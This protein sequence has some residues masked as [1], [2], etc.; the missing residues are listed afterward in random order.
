MRNSLG[1]FFAVYQLGKFVSGIEIIIICTAVSY[2]IITI[3]FMSH[4]ET[5]TV[6][7]LS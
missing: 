2:F 6:N 1:D 7:T 4:K 5:L 3:M